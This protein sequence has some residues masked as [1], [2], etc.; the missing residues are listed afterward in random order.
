MAGGHSAHRNDMAADLSEVRSEYRQ[1]A[2]RESEMDPDPIRQFERWFNHA[3]ESKLDMPNAMV[4]ATAGKD[5]RPSA[6]YVL[7]KKFDASGFVFYSH[8]MSLKGLQMAENPRAALAFYWAPQHR[9]VRV[10]G[11]VEVVPAA[12]AEEYFK[13]RPY[14]SRLSV[15]VA[16]QSSMVETREYLERRIVELDGQFH[17]GEV[18]RPES[19]VGYRVRPES[20]EFWQGRENRLHDRILYLCE[21][22]GRWTIKRLAP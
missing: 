18:P 1:A 19:W 11:A 17:D 2:L 8:S 9:Q 15:W 12:D 10:E 7:L 20:I 13:S 5:G 21:S 16:P 4:L 3:L 14:G 6:R 22:G